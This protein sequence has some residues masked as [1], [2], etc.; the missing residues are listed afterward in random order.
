V[1]QI[2]P[3]EGLSMDSALKSLRFVIQ[4]RGDELN[5]NYRL[6]VYGACGYHRHSDFGSAETLMK[7]IR[8]AIPDFDISW[9]AFDPS[10]E[11]C[12]SIIFVDGMVLDDLQFSTLGLNY[13]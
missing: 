11:R 6:V 1:N 5:T 3:E 9:L 12:G 10:E 7:T 2:L 4:R 13:F 8:I